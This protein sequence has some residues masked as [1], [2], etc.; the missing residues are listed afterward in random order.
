ME[1][2]IGKGGKGVG[3]V[4]GRDR[5][6]A[7]AFPAYLDDYV[8]EDNPVRFLDAFVQAL[9]L[10]DLG[11]DRAE[12]KDMGRPAYH[13]GLLLRVY[14]YGY[15]NNI[16]SSRKLEREAKRN[17]ELMW[18]MEML[19]P[20][21]KTI[22]DFRKD[23]LK[24][25]KKTCRQFT[26]LC[27]N[28]GLFGGELVAVDGS[29]FKAVNSRQRNFTEK[30]LDKLIRL[31]D[32]RIDE[33]LAEL[34]AADRQEDETQTSIT[35]E[36]LKEKIEELK[37]QKE[38]HKQRQEELEKS[39]ETQ[40]SETDPDARLMKTPDGMAVCYNVQI[41]VD[42]LHK[43]IGAHEV[44]NAG[45]D[46]GQLASIATQAKR[47]LGVESIEA[48]A[49]MGYYDCAQVKQCEEQGI[50]VYIQKP[51]LGEMKKGMF[52][53]NDFA[54]NAEKDVYVCPA[55]SE[56]TNKGRGIEK[57]RQMKYYTTAA[58]GSCGMKSQCT[59]GVGRRIKRLVDE[60]VMERMAA[61]VRAG[62][63]KLQ[64]RR[65]LVE[66]PFGTIK[67]WMG[68]GYFLMRGKAKVGTE[69]SLT[70]TAY[71]MKRVINITG[72][73]KMIEALG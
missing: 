70:V 30:K 4:S 35:G 1:E 65:E 38:Q 40:I 48:A 44:T 59:E 37:K 53:K 41:A 25:I 31:A 72:V 34:D 2:T 52:T 3:Y 61:R 69:M 19:T 50:T 45:S 27:K 49:D 60:E 26:E 62:P 39:G 22:A 18:L 5:R 13:P 51:P 47:T 42:S 68:Q 55:G 11:F 8:G 36:G 46:R 14:L 9:D 54:Y 23:N 17:V 20:D 56:L 73:K 29:K 24:P 28:M 16:R 64:L 71:N 63:E 43:L 58:C 10:A 21:H 67:R 57:G 15:L 32:Q 6:Q 66:H 12:P 7:V 33:Y